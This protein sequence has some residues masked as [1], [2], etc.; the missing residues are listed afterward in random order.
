[1]I[2]FDARNGIEPESHFNNN[3]KLPPEQWKFYACIQHSTAQYTSL[4]VYKL[5]EV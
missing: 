1:M 5:A 3:G 4:Q 2:E